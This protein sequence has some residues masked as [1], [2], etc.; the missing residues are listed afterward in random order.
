MAKLFLH[1]TLKPGV[2]NETFETWT[3]ST[4]Y[5]QMRSLKRISSFTT[6][7]IRGLLMGDDEIG[8]DYIEVFD[9]PDLEGFIAEDMGS[10]MVQSLMGQ[11]MAYVDNPRFIIADEVV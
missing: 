3:R 5:P 6:N 9:V 10:D 7:R 2:S 1:Y 11:F 4:D 8:I